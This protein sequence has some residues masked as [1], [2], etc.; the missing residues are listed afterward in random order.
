MIVAVWEPTVN[1][2]TR[3]VW[4]FTSVSLTRR[5]SV[6]SL[7]KVV[8][9]A[10]LAESATTVGASLT[11]ILRMPVEFAPTVSPWVRYAACKVPV[12]VSSGVKAMWP[13][14]S[15]C[16]SPLPAIVY[17]TPTS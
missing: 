11:L 14:A 9:S 1:D 10:R 7:D 13:L 15:I 12:K 8:S 3:N 16:R 4:S 6:E 2:V 17:V 5:P